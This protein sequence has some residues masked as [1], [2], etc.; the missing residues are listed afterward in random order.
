MIKIIGAN[1]RSEDEPEKDQWK[2]INKE[3]KNKL[4]VEK[5]KKKFE[6]QMQ[7]IYGYDMKAYFMVKE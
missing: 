7:V 2:P 6:K 3:F 5:Y 4:K 1:I